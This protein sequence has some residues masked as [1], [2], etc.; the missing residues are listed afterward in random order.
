MS[1]QIRSVL[2]ISKIL[3]GRKI[4]AEL[5]E[6]STLLGLLHELTDIYG[7][8]F[9]DAVCCDGG[10]A[11]NKAAILVNGSSAAAIGGVGIQL[12]DGD[13]VL[14]MPVISGG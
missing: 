6:Q 13:D 5:P 2:G 10:Y 11:E 4:Y 3:G 9:H 1:V 8:E 7:Q 14:I 12:K